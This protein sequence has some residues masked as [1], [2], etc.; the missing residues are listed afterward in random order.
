M[1]VSGNP[2]SKAWFQFQKHVA[3]RYGAEEAALARLVIIHD[4]LE[5]EPGKIKVK[6][7]GSARY[8]RAPH[9]HAPFHGIYPVDH[10][11]AD[12]CSQRSQWSQILHPKYAWNGVLAHRR[13]RWE[14][15]ESRPRRRRELCSTEDVGQ[16][17]IA[18]H[19][20]SGSC[21]ASSSGALGKTLEQLAR[22]R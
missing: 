5:K 17:A 10:S 12:Q 21:H 22:I 11:A 8:V 14:T 3:R 13:G 7:G 4:E 18:N 6:E 15:A 9:R 1:N 20:G 19:P 16:T 2:V